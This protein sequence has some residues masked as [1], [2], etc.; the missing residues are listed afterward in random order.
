MNALKEYGVSA[1]VDPWTLTDVTHPD[2]PSPPRRRCLDFKSP[3]TTT[4]TSGTRAPGDRMT[5]VK[6][7][8][9]CLLQQARRRG[10]EPGHKHS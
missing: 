7:E 4:A 3:Q 2:A 5:Q 6:D 8:P 1:A 9:T 10:S